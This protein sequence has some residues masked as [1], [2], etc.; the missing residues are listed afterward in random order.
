MNSKKKMKNLKGNSSKKMKNLERNYLNQ[1]EKHNKEMNNLKRKLLNQQEKQTQEFKAKLARLQGKRNSRKKLGNL[2]PGVLSEI[3]K[4][5]PIGNVSRVD[6][7]AL[8]LNPDRP[9]NWKNN[10][11]ERM[12]KAKLIRQMEK[13]LIYIRN[14]KDHYTPVNLSAVDQ[15]LIDSHKDVYIDLLINGDPENSQLIVPSRTQAHTK[16]IMQQQANQISSAT[17]HL[18][19]ALV[20]GLGFVQGRELNT[21]YHRVPVQWTRRMAQQLLLSCSQDI[22]DSYSYVY[23]DLIINGN[24]ESISL[25]FELLQRCSQEIKDNYAE[26]FIEWIRNG[27]RRFK[28]NGLELLM[29]CSQEIKD[30][31]A[32]VFIDWIRN[33][34]SKIGFAFLMK[35]SQEMRDYYVFYYIDWINNGND[36]LRPMGLELFKNCTPQTIELYISNINMQTF[37]KL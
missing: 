1:R 16:D 22:V 28:E 33:G 7:T 20:S 23:M 14:H 25:G 29:K 36:M 9:T 27:D 31:Y 18:G 37:A 17:R 34:D 21:F 3:S 4:H 10:F 30:N 35:C 11:K 26:V 8:H 15:E 24:D 6:M 2:P 13:L 19:S 12:S 32:E 5:L